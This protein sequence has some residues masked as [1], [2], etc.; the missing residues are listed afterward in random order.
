MKRI[1]SLLLAVIMLISVFAGFGIN[2]QAAT[3]G[4]A[5]VAYA[6]QYVGYPYVST[7]SS[8]ETGFDCSGFTMYVYG[9][10]GVTL[11]HSSSTIYNNPENYGTLIGTDDYSKALPGDLVCWSGHIGIYSGIYEY[12]GEY[13]GFLVDAANSRRGV[14]E[15]PIWPSNGTYKIIRLKG[16]GNPVTTGEMSV[17]VVS[18]DKSSYAVGD[19]V[20]VIWAST[21][22]SSDFK[23]YQ[24][25]ISNNSTGKIVFSGA[26]GT[27]GNPYN[28]DY[29]FRIPTPGTYRIRV[30]AIPYNDAESRQKSASAYVTVGNIISL[31]NDYSASDNTY[32]LADGWYCDGTGSVYY[33]SSKQLKTGW[34][35]YSGKWYNFDSNGALRTF[36]YLE[37]GNWYFLGAGAMYTGWGLISGKWYYFS[38]SGVMQTGWLKVK[39]TWYYFDENGAMQTD[40]QEISGNWYYLGEDGAMQ[41][42]WVKL[43]GKWYYLKS[44]GA[45]A[46]GWQKIDGKWY[47]FSQKGIMATGWLLNG[48]AWYY[49]NSGGDMAIGWKQLSGKW[50]F[51]SSSGAM[52]TGKQSISDVTYYFNADGVMQ[53]GWQKLDEVWYYFAD[54]GAMATGWHKV[55]NFWYYFDE[56]GAM[57]TGWLD[58]SGTKYYLKQSGAMATGWQDIDGERYYFNDSGTMKKGWLLQNDSW[59]YLDENGVMLKDTTQTINNIEYIFD[60]NGIC[61]NP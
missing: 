5:V 50:Y 4:D 41:T 17:P 39:N 47:Y 34:F 1:C 49:L 6:R 59:Y 35:K 28:T 21:S 12:N 38:N 44:S 42:G 53:T 36:W 48:G 26:V 11:P 56:S 27:E 61:T 58:I 60:E 52:V 22:A 10:F 40:W 29:S 43:D 16:I 19:T 23:N 33:V 18:L 55:G 7:G 51:L 15:Q 46:T 9:H 32:N 13:R 31:I 14:V 8:P 20:H 24:V 45:M 3:S 2:A 30:F 57:Q 54:S 37:N 25:V